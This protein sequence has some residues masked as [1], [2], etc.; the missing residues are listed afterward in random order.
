MNPLEIWEAHGAVQP[1]VTPGLGD[2][3]SRA[4]TSWE[5]AQ[6]DGQGLWIMKGT[7]DDQ[8]GWGYEESHRPGSGTCGR[9][10]RT[11]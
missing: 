5:G 8:E 3:G 9:S 4:V 1:R 10:Q 6:Y 7:L 11:R 2:G